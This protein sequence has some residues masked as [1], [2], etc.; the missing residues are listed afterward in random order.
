MAQGLGQGSHCYTKAKSNPVV[1]DCEGRDGKSE[2]N[3]DDADNNDDSDD[4]ENNNDKAEKFETNDG[5]KTNGND[6]V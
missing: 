5:T 1:R 2:E 4:I 6:A 3:N